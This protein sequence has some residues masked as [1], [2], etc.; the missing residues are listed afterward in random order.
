MEAVH[1]YEGTVNQVMGDGIIALFGAPLAHEHY[2]QTLPRDFDVS[3]NVDIV[4]FN[5]LGAY[6]LEAQLASDRAAP[7]TS[8]P[9]GAPE[10]RAS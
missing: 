8:T 3:P 5:T 7:E 6:G 10:R 1:R 2:S 9:R 4:K